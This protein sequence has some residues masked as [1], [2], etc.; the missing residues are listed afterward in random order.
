MTNNQKGLT[1]VEVLA[2]IVLLSIIT[3]LTTMI[4]IQ[5]FKNDETATEEIS[6]K[7]NSNIILSSLSEAFNKTDMKDICI[8]TQ[9]GIIINEDNSNS[10][11]TSGKSNNKLKNGCIMDIDREKPLIVKLYIENTAQTDHLVVETTLVKS[12]QQTVMLTQDEADKIP[13]ISKPDKSFKRVK[14]LTCQ[15]NGNI[16]WNGQKTSCS[17]TIKINGSIYVDDELDYDKNFVLDVI[18]DMHFKKEV[19]LKKSK[20]TATGSGCFKKEADLEDSEVS[21]GG[22]TEFRDDF[23][24]DNSEFTT[25][26]PNANPPSFTFF[27]KDVD[28]DKS[29][30]I[31]NGDAIFVKEFDFD[32]DS[33][34][35]KYTFKITNNA[36]FRDEMDFE[37]GTL[38]IDGGSTFKK[39][40]DFDDS[41]IS[42]GKDAAFTKKADF[43]NSNATIGLNAY[44]NDEVDVDN[45]KLTIN[46][47]LT[48]SKG[49]F[50]IKNSSVL[51]VGGSA[52]FAK[53]PQ[54]SSSSTL[55]IKKG[56]NNCTS[57]K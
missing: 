27:K 39:E 49:D 53:S 35:K 40:A 31:I 56:T 13:C 50:E 32:G 24:L 2:G 45:S 34:N 3:T 10:V 25:G 1:L 8:N 21:F 15:E 14:E 37:D 9:P 6:L 38:T 48:S 33:N 4:L 18:G 41:I 51:T 42:I 44:F 12:N 55:C 52:T 43:K 19:D 26:K 28:I 20:L 16:L 23:D 7:Q 54:V 57:Y 17:G 11:V 22:T 47:N 46:Q 36:D 29:S 30:V 5:I